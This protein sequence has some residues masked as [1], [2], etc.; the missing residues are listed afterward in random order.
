MRSG[1]HAKA[2]EA[3]YRVSVYLRRLSAWLRH[4]SI[5]SSCRRASF[6]NSLVN[7]QAL[8]KRV[9]SGQ[10]GQPEQA[11]EQYQ[12]RALYRINVEGNAISVWVIVIICRHRRACIASRRIFLKLWTI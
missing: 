8:G 1:E 6:T 5:R 9:S 11:L 10:C 4:F 2:I 7:I 12:W 3:L